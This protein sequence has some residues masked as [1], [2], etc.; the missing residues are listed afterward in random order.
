MIVFAVVNLKGGSQKTTSTGFLL[1]A[2]H[3]SGLSVCGVDADGENLQLQGWQVDAN[4]P[5][6]VIAM[7]VSNLH[8][9]LP[10]ILGD[11]YEAVGI[12][13]PPMQA[14]KGTVASAIRYATHVLITMAPTAA[15]HDRLDPVVELIKDSASL[16]PDGKPPAHAVLLTK[17][18]PK[19]ASP[20]AYRELIEESGVRV[21]KAQ[22]GVR[23][24]FAQAIGSP[25]KNALA[26]PYGDAAL[27]LM[28]MEN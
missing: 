7:P 24:M 26:T 12:D 13:T 19:A 14:Q 4:L 27:E 16:R 22:V 3:E 15:D 5:F 25:V 1:S 18:P 9:Q 20:T 10:G 2:L 23:E 6:P 8:A 11:R 21:L 28:D 17:C